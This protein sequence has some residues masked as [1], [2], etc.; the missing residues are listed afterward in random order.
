M[1]PSHR[2]ALVSCVS[3]SIVFT[4]VLASTVGCHRQQPGTRPQRP[5]PDSVSDGYTDKSRDNAGG[6]ASK[7][8]GGASQKKVQRVEELFEGIAGLDVRRS[9]DGGYSVSVRGGGSFM[10]GE[11]P[12]YV[13]D[14]VPFDYAQGRGLAWLSPA[15]VVRISVLKNPSD[16]AIYGVR[17]A[18][19]VI[20]ITTKRKK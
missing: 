20:V 18:N 5:A 17:G 2:R 8:L 16:T 4:L 6:V 12:L 3:S 14:G 9:T 10:A 7:T 15:D 13:I 1:S 19:G 11:Q